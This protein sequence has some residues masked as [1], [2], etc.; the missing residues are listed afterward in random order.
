MKKKMLFVVPVMIEADSHK[1]FREAIKSF[2]LDSGSSV[3]GMQFSWEQKGRPYL[4][5]GQKLPSA[6]DE[7]KE[8]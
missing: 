2:R 3:F 6:A 1:G 8:K 7:R 4:L 5:P